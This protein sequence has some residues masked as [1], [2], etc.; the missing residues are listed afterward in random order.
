MMSLMSEFNEV[1]D[2]GT[3]K[4]NV[5][6]PK[7]DLSHFVNRVNEIL[8]D[9]GGAVNVI[10]T[11]QRSLL[12]TSVRARSLDVVRLLLEHRAIL[13]A[14]DSFGAKPIEYAI[15]QNAHP[16]V[17]VLLPFVDQSARFSQGNSMIHLAAARADLLMVRLLITHGQPL[18]ARN[19]LGETPL[20]VAVQRGNVQVVDEL[21]QMG[22]NL[23]AQNQAGQTGLTMAASGGH[24]LIFRLMLHQARPG[25]L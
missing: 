9:S 24:E 1:V 19:Q 22:A 14:V 11:N 4:Q 2:Q 18:E 15:Q 21:V 5:F 20:H 6:F 16:I 25:D 7:T 13:D 17:S 3:L 10:D 8:F 23:A 12:H